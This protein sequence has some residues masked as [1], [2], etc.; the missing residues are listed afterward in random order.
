MNARRDTDRIEVRSSVRTV[1]GAVVLL[2]IDSIVVL[3]GLTFIIL[4]ILIK[5]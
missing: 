1:S 4:V 3:L 5:G 2:P